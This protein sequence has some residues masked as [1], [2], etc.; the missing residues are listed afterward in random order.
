[1]E[2]LVVLGG[3]TTVF[4]SGTH[5]EMDVNLRFQAQQNARLALSRIRSDAHLAG[6]TGTGTNATSISFYS[7]AAAPGSCT[8]TATVT[9]CTAGSAQLA[10]R[11]TLYRQAGGSC[12]SS[13]GTF[14]ADYLTT[15]GLFT[16]NV[17]TTGSGQR[18]SVTVSF[19]VSTNRTSANLDR[20]TLSDTLVLRNSPQA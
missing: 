10:N 20:Y 13:T 5:A 12:S 2:M 1:M 4:V 15:N 14:V 3:L 18:T 9:W 8:G 17:P 19:P 11:W 16:T 7:A 6:C